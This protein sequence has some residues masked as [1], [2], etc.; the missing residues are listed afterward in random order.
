MHF[1]KF[2]HWFYYVYADHQHCSHHGDRTNETQEKT[3]QSSGSTKAVY[4]TRGHQTTL[5]LKEKC[6]HTALFI[7]YR[8]FTLYSITNGICS[9]GLE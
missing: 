6:T 1:G 9:P 8:K 3:N 5:E 7:I 2:Y 4:H